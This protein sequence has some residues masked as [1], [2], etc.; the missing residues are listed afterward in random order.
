VP[1]NFKRHRIG[2][3]VT[4]AI[5]QGGGIGRY[6]R[7]LVRALIRKDDSSYYILFSGKAPKRA[8]VAD[9]IPEASNV[10]YREFWLNAKW[11]YRLW[12]RLRL[13][14]SVQW[15]T[16]D[17]DIY[18]SP[19]F[20]LPPTGNI[21]SV[22]T[23]HDLSF[24]HYPEAFTPALLNYLNKAV[25]SSIARASHVLADSLSTKNDLVD[26]WQVPKE[27]ISVIYS[28]VGSSFKPVTEKD[29]IQRVRQ[30]Y[31]LGDKPFIFSVG[32]LQPRKNYEMLIR[33]FKPISETTTHQL[34]IAGGFGWMYKQILEE[35]SRLGLTE[36]VKLIGFVDDQDLPALYS[37][38]SLFAF[39]SLYEGFG[40][41]L[42]EA[43][44]CGVPVI[45]SNASSLPEVAGDAALLLP[46]D[47]QELWSENLRQL[48]EDSSRRTKMVA[49]GFLQARK[50]SWRTAAEHVLNIYHTL[51]PE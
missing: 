36:R 48:L 31:E 13:P 34:V 9:P 22:L 2:I 41:P 17:I 6:T 47:A 42:L 4:A 51:L 50:Y 45:S 30:K 43:M 10:E 3:D 32:T 16:G 49:A 44:S 7:E 1:D 25:P 33:A 29:V 19:D 20:V 14:I 37:D 23:I 46:P 39:P 40:I 27:K 12:Y 5:T 24:V 35:A 11:L 38:A 21:P 18:H 26:I 15:L 28:G 8:L